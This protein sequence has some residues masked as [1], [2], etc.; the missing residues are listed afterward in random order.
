MLRA[1]ERSAAA[2]GTARAREWCT[3]SFLRRVHLMLCA[4]T[5]AHWRDGTRHHSQWCSHR[6]A[7]TSRAFCTARVAVLYAR[8]YDDGSM[9]RCA[10]A[11]V[12]PPLARVHPF[13]SLSARR[14]S[15][16]VNSDA[17]PLDAG[18]A[19]LFRSTV[20]A[21]QWHDDVAAT[22]VRMRQHLLSWRTLDCRR[23]RLSSSL[24]AHGIVRAV[25]ARPNER[26]HAAVKHT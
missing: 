8:L 11:S 24:A 10:L 7:H 9:A 25:L 13:S 21:M 19:R 12:I 16:D 26:K 17:T 18:R 2:I 4:S 15:A 23:T 14:H 22:G 6:I 1:G 20:R 3:F 5:V